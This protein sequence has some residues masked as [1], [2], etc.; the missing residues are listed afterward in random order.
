[1]VIFLPI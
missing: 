1:L